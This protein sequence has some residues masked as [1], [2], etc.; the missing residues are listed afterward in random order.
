[1]PLHQSSDGPF[2]LRPARPEALVGKICR[3][4]ESDPANPQWH[5]NA[6]YRHM[7][8]EEETKSM[9][10]S[11]QQEQRRGDKAKDSWC[12]S[13]PLS[14]KELHTRAVTFLPAL[15]SS[16]R[17]NLG[18]NLCLIY[19]ACHSTLDRMRDYLENGFRHCQTD[20]H[21]RDAEVLVETSNDR[22]QN[23]N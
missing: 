10:Y 23:G 22:R 17:L 2:R 21:V 5:G 15:A 12:H 4:G 3:D 6:F 14:S 11:Y 7:P 18:H 20:P 9:P 8:A 13:P 1:M 19:R 16:E